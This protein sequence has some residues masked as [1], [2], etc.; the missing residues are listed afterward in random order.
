M[1]LSLIYLIVR[2]LLSVPAL[3]IRRDL[4]TGVEL[5]VLRH[6]N[7]V[8]APPDRPGSLYPGRP[9]MAGRA[10]ATHPTLTM[11]TVTPATILTWHRRLVTRKWDYSERRQ[12]GRPPTAAAIKK[13]V[14]RMAT[15]NPQWGH[16]RIHGELARLGHRIGASTVWEI[17]HIAGIEPAPP[18]VRPHL[19]AVPR[20]T[21]QRH[22]GSGLRARGHGVPETD[23]RADRR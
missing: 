10:V 9:T 22:H 12:P 21:G 14:I 7:V 17:L 18:P 11:F 15:D 4:S 2:H 19:E 1:L 13:L 23:L 20:S 5:L 3:L 16:R 6:E 8:A